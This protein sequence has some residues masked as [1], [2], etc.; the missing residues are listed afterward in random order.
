VVVHVGARWALAD[1]PAK[2]GVSAA[3]RGRSTSWARA[4]RPSSTRRGGSHLWPR[5]RRCLSEEELKDKD[6]A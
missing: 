6:E 3:A 1:R 2:R 5:P 4:K